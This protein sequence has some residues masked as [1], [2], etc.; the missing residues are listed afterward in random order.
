MERMERLQWFAAEVIPLATGR[1]SPTQVYS[2][3]LTFRRNCLQHDPRRIVARRTAPP[4]A[5]RSTSAKNTAPPCAAFAPSFS[6]AIDD[7]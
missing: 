1:G 3:D 6:A 4:A 7:S 5:R 2:A